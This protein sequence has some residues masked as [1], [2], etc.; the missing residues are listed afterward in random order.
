MQACAER[1]TREIRFQPAADGFLTISRIKGGLVWR[2]R[3]NRAN[4]DTLEDDRDC[5]LTRSLT[6]SPFSC[7]IIP[8]PLL[9]I[10]E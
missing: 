5:A 9:F 8:F 6:P 1:G 3:K 7:G 4:N 2:T 10:S